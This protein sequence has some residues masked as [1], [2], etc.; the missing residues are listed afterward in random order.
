MEETNKEIKLLI[1]VATE[2]ERKILI[3]EEVEKLP[4]EVIVTGIG[5]NSVI[6]SVREYC[7]D[8]V[9]V[10]N[11]GLVAGT[12][13]VPKDTII[14]VTAVMP[15]F[16]HGHFQ[17]PISLTLLSK[18]NAYPCVSAPG[19]ITDVY[20]FFPESCYS[21]DYVVDMELYTIA[22]F[23]KDTSALKV[24]SDDGEFDDY[25]STIEDYDSLA[26]VRQQIYQLICR[27]LIK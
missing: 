20:Q 25:L 7:Y 5:S 8:A 21:H 10:L 2:Q 6:N 26:P 16:N 19:F 15:G 18:E 4:I 3:S 14:P 1:L 11:I 17:Q 12:Q 24:V 9:P 13:G 27:K 22:S 23:F